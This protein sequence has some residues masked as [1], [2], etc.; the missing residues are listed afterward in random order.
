MEEGGIEGSGTCFHVPAGGLPVPCTLLCFVLWSTSVFRANEILD[1]YSHL[2]AWLAI[3]VWL[4]YV[5]ATILLF[6]SRKST[7]GAD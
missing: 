1:R 4:L 5:A 7:R 6:L 3:V 2:A